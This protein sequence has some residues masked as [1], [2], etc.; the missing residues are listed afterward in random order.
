MPSTRAPYNNLASY[1]AQVAGVPAGSP[2][3]VNIP[4]RFVEQTQIL[5]GFFPQTQRVAWLT[6]DFPHPTFPIWMVLG[7]QVI[8]E[9]G[10]SDRVEVA[11]LPGVLWQQLMWE[12]LFPEGEPS[13]FRIWLGAAWF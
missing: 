12:Q 1:W 8:T 6:Y 9:Y 13:Y 5:P 3:A 7:S 4:C 2:Y 10:D 11:T